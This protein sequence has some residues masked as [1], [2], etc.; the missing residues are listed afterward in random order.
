VLAGEVGVDLAHFHADDLQRC[1]LEPLDNTSC[2]AAGDGIR[3]EHDERALA[4]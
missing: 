1:V 2:Q 4:Q 3:L